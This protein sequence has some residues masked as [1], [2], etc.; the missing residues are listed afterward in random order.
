MPRILKHPFLHI[1]A[2]ALC[3]LAI[4]GMIYFLVR[5]QLDPVASLTLT[6]DYR[7]FIEVRPFW[8][9]IAAQG[10]YI[11]GFLAIPF[12]MLRLRPAVWLFALS[13]IAAVVTLP[14]TFILGPAIIGGIMLFAAISAILFTW[15]S[16][17]YVK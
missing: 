9:L 1:C 10:T 16:V 5:E 2:V 8:E 14:P 4:N 17:K 15:F 12:L 6:D 13:A 7:Y 3:A 11:A